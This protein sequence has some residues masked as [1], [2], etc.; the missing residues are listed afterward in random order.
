[1]NDWSQP[2]WG[3]ETTRLHFERHLTALWRLL[4]RRFPFLRGRP[5]RMDAA[6]RILGEEL[7][8][9]QRE[10]CGLS[11]A[12]RFHDLGLLG[13]PDGIVLKVGPLS[14][15]ERRIYNEHTDCGGRLVATIF[16]D[17][18]DAVQAVW[19]HHERP[20]GSGPHHVTKDD[21]PPMASIIQLAQAVEAM[22]NERPHRAAVSFNAIM[23]E[24][25]IYEGT[26]FCR[27]VVE[28]FRRR[29]QDIYRLLLT[30]DR[31]RKPG[32]AEVVATGS[33][34]TAFVTA[35]TAPRAGP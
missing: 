23:H 8:F 24:L 19:F 7:K 28:A 11:L 9:S 5:A 3:D 25:W 12:A 34:P 2:V 30:D 21:I 4:A 27:T 26:H 22:A 33:A 20:D 17:F 16:P 35:R 13:V 10:L 32:G 31:R 15:E 18:P 6:C 29:A 14:A 1:M